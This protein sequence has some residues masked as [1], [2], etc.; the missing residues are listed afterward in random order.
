LLLPVNLEEAPSAG[1][2]AKGVVLR[3]CM[4]YFHGRVEKLRQ[5]AYARGEQ[6]FS[7][8]GFSL[9]GFDLIVVLAKKATG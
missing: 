6:A 5:F 2:P 4:L 3:K 8:T 1:Y 9:S 7:R